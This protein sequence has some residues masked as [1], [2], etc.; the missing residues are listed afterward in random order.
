MSHFLVTG[1]AGFIGS[2]LVEKLVKLGHEVRVLDSLVT[3][4]LDNLASVAGH[5]EWL[6]ADAAD[7]GKLRQAVR[8]V[9][10]VF[11]LASIP[12]VPLSIKHPRKNQQAGEVATLVVLDEAA[13]AGVR[14]LIYSSSAAVYSDTGGQ[15]HRENA[16]VG[17][18]NFYGLSK[19]TSEEYCRLFS[20]FHKIDTVSLRYF[21]V[22]GPRQDPTNSYSGVISIFCQSLRGSVRPTIFGDGQ[23]TRDFIEVSDIVESNIAAMQ[24]PNRLAG[25]AFNVGSGSSITVLQLWQFLA[26]LAG[27]KL[28]PVFAPEREG[29]IKHSRANIGKLRTVLKTE[30]KVSWKDGLKKL[31]DTY[32]KSEATG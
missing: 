7:V 19:L 30:P 1:G 32:Q 24:A 29:E 21:N 16:H 27:S 5:F 13:R 18:L 2:H 6:Q 3:G 28:V 12:S 4:T 23:Q 17:P 20:R 26:Q 11:H 14:R 15:P 22:F 8:D 25:D 9:E 10:G 31:W